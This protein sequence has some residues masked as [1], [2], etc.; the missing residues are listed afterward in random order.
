MNLSQ[1]RKKTQEVLGY[2]FKDYSLLDIALT[3]SSVKRHQK[4]R[5]DYENLEFLGDSILNMMVAKIIYTKHPDFKE[6]RLTSLRSAIINNQNLSTTIDKL[7]L[8]EVLQTGRGQNIRASMKADMFEAILAA[9][10][11]DSSSFDE[12]EKII[13]KIYE[14]NW[15]GIRGRKDDFKT[16]LQEITQGQNPPKLPIYKVLSSKGPQHKK[17]FIVEVLVDSKVL[18]SGKG[19]NKKSAEQEAAKNA[20]KK[21]KNKGSN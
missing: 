8:T 17:V 7:G 5:K 19:Y 12:V 16:Q 4:Q 2:N 3:H 21:M 15:T 1:A 6:G 14:D 11:L 20:L 9:I 10:Y 18:G 13:K